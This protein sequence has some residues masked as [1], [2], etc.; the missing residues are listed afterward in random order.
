[1][2][3]GLRVR[4]VLGIDTSCDDT[5]VAIYEHGRGVI[6]SLVSSQ[7]NIHARFGGV[8]PELASRRHLELIYPLLEEVLKRGGLPL[9]QIEGVAVTVGPGLIGSLLV[10][11]SVAKA[12]AYARKIPLVGVNHL[13][14]HIL[15]MELANPSLEYPYT[16]L[17]VSGGHTHLF[18]VE[19]EGQYCLLGRTRDDAAGEA[20]DK[21]AKLLGLDY[22]GGPSIERM[23]ARG[24]PGFVSL[25][26]GMA[27]DG[28]F[29]FSFS[30][31]KTAVSYL[32]ER[33]RAEGKDPCQDDE[34]RAHI[35][36][37]FQQAA[38]EMCA[39]TALKAAKARR[40]PRIVLVGGVACNRVLRDLLGRMA[41]EEGIEIHCPPPGLCTDNADMVAY[42]GFKRLSRGEEAPLSLNAYAR[43]PLA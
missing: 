40:S 18:Q 27:Q 20:F 41:A 31:L 36:A 25:P 24:D 35:A 10:G 28:S 32:V 7:V 29:D 16:A 2:T 42:A 23:A 33:M 13:E 38:V 30:G 19:G 15:A 12:V 8:V 39:R 5:A 6:S 4:R 1:M 17:V 3:R 9:S 14:G 21:V 43:L 11:L 37:S 34:L 22:P 26:R